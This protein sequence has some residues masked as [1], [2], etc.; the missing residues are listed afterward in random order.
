[1]ETFSSSSPE[2]TQSP[3]SN[4]SN[5]NYKN[6]KSNS[7]SEKPN[8]INSNLDIKPKQQKPKIRFK[9]RKKKKSCKRDVSGAQKSV[10]HNS[11][12][13]PSRMK[14]RRF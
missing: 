8:H 1:M 7:K 2:I 14:E 13:A 10:A 12:I 6:L 5:Q 9:K 11:T 4:P 3:D